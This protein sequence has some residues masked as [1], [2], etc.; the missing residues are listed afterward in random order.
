MRVRR[1]GPSIILTARSISTPFP[2]L[3]TQTPPP[4]LPSGLLLLVLLAHNFHYVRVNVSVV[5]V[6]EN[7]ETGVEKADREDCTS[8]FCCFSLIFERWRTGDWGGCGCIICMY[9]RDLLYTGGGVINRNTAPNRERD[10]QG[11]Q[12]A[13]QLGGGRGGKGRY[14]D[15]ANLDFKLNTRGPFSNKS[16]YSKKGPRAMNRFR[17]Q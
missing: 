6:T 14:A 4:L 16:I 9:L 11:T 5:V 10:T 3:L 15:D 12:A 17:L 13:H 1:C 8:S 2:L 7:R